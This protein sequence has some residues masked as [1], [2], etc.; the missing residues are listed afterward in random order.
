MTACLPAWPVPARGARSA[1]GT[2]AASLA[3]HRYCAARL[4]P[5][6]ICCGWMTASR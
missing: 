6:T 3:I 1:R 4:R 2:Q 5:A